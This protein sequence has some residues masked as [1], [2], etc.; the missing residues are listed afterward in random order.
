MKITEEMIEAGVKAYAHGLA[1]KKKLRRDII[2]E[3]YIAMCTA[4]W[5]H[6]QELE[7]EPT[8]EWWAI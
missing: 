3:I 8:A 7:Q 1:D 6:L 4:R 5:E 2:K